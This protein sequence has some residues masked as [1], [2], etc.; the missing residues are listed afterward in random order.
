M[1]EISSSGQWRRSGIFI[2]N[3]E[4]I[5]LN[6]LVFPM[7]TLDR[8][9]ILVLSTYLWTW[10]SVLRRWKRAI[11]NLS[12]TSSF[13][14]IKCHTSSRHLNMAK[15]DLSMVECHRS[16]AECKDQ[17]T[18]NNSIKGIPIFDQIYIRWGHVNMVR[19]IIACHI[20]NIALNTSRLYQGSR[21]GENF[22]LI[23]LNFTW[24]WIQNIEK[25]LHGRFALAL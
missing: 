8:K 24:K 6:V 7:L 2:I 1:C 14:S 12:K 20:N 22:V 3:F 13:S 23:Q 10:R 19:T 11:M 4:Q 15:C 21:W 25:H 16:M 17:Y 9:L 5:P 18:R